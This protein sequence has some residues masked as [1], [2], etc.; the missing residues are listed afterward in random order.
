VHTCIV[1]VNSELMWCVLNQSSIQ[2]ENSSEF[3]GCGVSRDSS[4]PLCDEPANFYY[5]K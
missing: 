3:S 4:Q 1:M 2:L 5:P